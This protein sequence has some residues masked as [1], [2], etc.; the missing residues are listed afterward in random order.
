[1]ITP[2][3]TYKLYFFDNLKKEILLYYDRRYSMLYYKNNIHIACSWQ[4]FLSMDGIMGDKN[5]TDLSLTIK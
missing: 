1:M 4:L 2:N 3:I 5:I